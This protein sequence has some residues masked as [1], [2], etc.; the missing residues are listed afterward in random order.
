MLES[1]SHRI[2]GVLEPER[3][4]RTPAPGGCKSGDL[5]IIV[6]TTTTVAAAQ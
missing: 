5:K 4:Q 2:I 6:T 3:P 1:Q